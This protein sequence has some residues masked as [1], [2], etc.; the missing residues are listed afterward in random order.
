LFSCESQKR[1][2]DIIYSRYSGQPGFTMVALPPNFVDNFVKED[3]K[4][5]KELLNQMRDLRVMIFEDKIEGKEGKSVFDDV[6]NLLD[7]RNFEE[8]MSINK[9]GSRVT[10][11]IQQRKDIVREMHV[12]VRG[13][14]KF[15]IASLTGRI[16]L[17]TISKAMNEINFNDFKDLEGF[18]KDFDFEP[19]DFK[20]SF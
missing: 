14:N 9:D 2:S 6:N 15:F 17:N 4:E 3:Q 19:E 8:M 5:E 12:L 1:I 7:K 10:V 11:K 18:T 13:E 20:I 16:D